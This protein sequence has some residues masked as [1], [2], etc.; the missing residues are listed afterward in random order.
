MSYTAPTRD[1]AFA[2]SELA[3]L[4]GVSQLP[5][6]EEATADMLEAILEEAGKF[7]SEVLAP[8]NHSGDQQGARLENGQAVTADGWK[9]A[10]QQFIESGWNGLPF[11]PEY[12]GQ[13][14][15]WLI[16]TA[17]NEIWHAS[18][19]AFALCPLLTQGAIEAILAHGSAQQQ[20]DYLSKLVSGEWTGTMN[21]TE[22]QAGSDLSAVKTRAKPNGDH[23]LLSGQKIFITYGDHDLTENI[24]HLVLAR[25]PD[26][27][28]GVKGISLFIVPKF[29]RDED[30]SWTRRND[31]ETLS[32]EK[33]L[34]IHASPTAVLGYGNNGG[35][36]GY[37]V[38]EENQGLMYMFT[39][40]NVARH[41]VGVQ[42]YALADRAYQQAVQF[43]SDRTQGRA[44]DSPSGERV[45][46][47][48]HPDVQR[49]L[50][51]QKCR[52]ESL[53]SLGLVTAAC[54]DKAERHPEA[55]TRKTA[56]EI[57][58]VMTP[59]V[60]GYSTEIGLENVSLALQIHGGMGFIEET[61]AAQHYRDQ[62]I[63]PIYEGTTGIQA[64]D[65]LGRK[66]LR[67]GGQMMGRVI[68][69]IRQD[70]TELTTLSKDMAASLQTGLDLLSTATKEL[71]EAAGKDIR[72]PAAVAE[73][74]LR[75]WGVVVCG[76]Q[77][78]KAAHRS[79]VLI[80]QGASDSFYTNKIRTAEFYFSSEM[81]KMICLAETIRMSGELV[82]ETET[83]VFQVA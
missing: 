12:G 80:E 60:K 14:L 53:R 55:E 20:Q 22:P 83:E 33:K 2:C 63:T 47:I 28:E 61:G 37:L 7:G 54:M 16:A 31:V 18:N 41:S 40:M 65:L 42:G 27:P 69:Y 19:M 1:L 78:A 11:S 3:D 49:L 81:P 10:Y 51:V 32:L 52:N 35:A 67:D 25:L 58:E 9:P 57:V 71:A 75:L 17:V 34:G 79:K 72:V 29:L 24:V 15:P 4:E 48:D 66:L 36:V 13:G 70:S 46:I 59:I 82:S 26:A 8:I 73:P 6:F 64:M 62:R 30:G 23:Y 74:N 45:S 77:M 43:A 56:E 5:G 21:L 44:I 39:M 68:D 38:G 50:W 76:W